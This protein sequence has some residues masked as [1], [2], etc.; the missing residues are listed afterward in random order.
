MCT[1]TYRHG[2]LVCAIAGVALASLSS[3]ESATACS[4]ALPP[5]E[6]FGYPEN[7]AADVPTDVLPMYRR[8]RL[9]G[10]RGEPSFELSSAAGQSV[11]LTKSSG[12][13]WYIELRPSQDL[14]PSTRYVLRA[15]GESDEAPLQIEFTTGDG[16]LSEIPA[17]PAIGLQ[18]YTLRS[19]TPTTCSPWEN[20]T[21]VSF[22]DASDGVFVEATHFVSGVDNSDDGY[23]YVSRD[24][25][26][27]NIAGLPDQGTP[28]DC[29]RFRNRA[30]NGSLSEPTVRCREDGELVA[31]VGSED[32]ACTSQGITQD[33]L[34]LGEP[35]VET[36]PLSTP[37]SLD[38]S[39]G[40]EVTPN[41]E[42][43]RAIEGRGCSTAPRGGAHATSFSAL[44]CGAC[45]VWG[46]RR[47]ARGP[48]TP[49]RLRCS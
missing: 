33:G 43:P 31:I 41:D 49:A 17:P 2:P 6:L 21:C 37:D 24:P 8:S 25:W 40:G 10:Y 46:W 44:L 14:D 16:P 34:P 47:R 7:G 1:M 30:A 11:P 29:V 12:G 23:L 45:S 20:G 4:V 38:D 35:S 36:T 39:A 15:S 18:H 42:S 48:S 19:F 28:W 32:I 13:G 5:P 9:E 3:V 22:P 27:I 26:F